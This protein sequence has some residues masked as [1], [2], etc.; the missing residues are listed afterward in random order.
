MAASAASTTPASN[1][2][3][4]SRPRRPGPQPV[5]GGARSDRGLGDGGVV[6]GQHE[7]VATPAAAFDHRDDHAGAAVG[8]H[9]S[10]HG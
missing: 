3:E 4:T 7:A 2:R 6:G 1:R 10:L 9:R 8:Q 5:R